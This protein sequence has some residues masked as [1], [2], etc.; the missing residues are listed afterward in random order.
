MWFENHPWVFPIIIGSIGVLYLIY[1][2]GT[3]IET[4]RIQAKGSDHHISGIP[5]LGGVHLL[6]AGLIS[7]IKWLALFCVLDYTFWSFLYA[8]F[9]GDCFK[10]ND[11]QLQKPSK[12]LTHVEYEAFGGENRSAVGE[13]K[14][15]MK[16]TFVKT[17][18]VK[19]SDVPVLLMLIIFSV[20]GF[21][22][23]NVISGYLAGV[24][25]ILL[26]PYLTLKRPFFRADVNGISYRRP[27]GF[28]YGKVTFIEWEQVE[29]I[30]LGD[31]IITIDE[32]SGEISERTINEES[33]SDLD[34][35][36]GCTQEEYED[37]AEWIENGFF[38]AIRQTEK[39]KPEL[40]E[41]GQFIHKNLDMLKVLWLHH[42]RS[43]QDHRD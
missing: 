8:V 9:I 32:E 31:Q 30:I 24:P 34:V 41:L 1:N 22:G 43:S 38:I 35:F 21:A 17:S 33:L 15:S 4:K 28:R 10:K 42:F 2:I 25:A 36:A 14:D 26:F 19:F 16:V 27:L 6:I 7:P 12:D 3:I 11:R 40:I 13:Q 5:F 20:A 23:G 29:A 39:R 18:G 37:R